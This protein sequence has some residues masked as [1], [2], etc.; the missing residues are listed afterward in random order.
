MN[1]LDLFDKL[2]YKTLNYSVLLKKVRFDSVVRYIIG[3]TANL[4]LPIYFSISSNNEGYKLNVNDDGRQQKLVVSLTSFPARIA[5]VH[6]VIEC[7]LRQTIKPSVII[8]WLSKQQFKSLN[9]L[10]KALLDLQ[11]RGL[12]IKIVN[13][14]IRSHKKYYYVMKT[15]PNDIII[16]VD[17]DIFYRS[18]MIQTLLECAKDNPSSIIANYA[19]RIRYENH[20][21]LP[22]NLWENNV[23]LK[24]A[25]GYDIFFGS[26]GGTLFRPRLLSP[27]VLKKEVFLK[28]CS[29]ADDIWLNAMCRINGTEVVKT[30]Y[31]SILLPVLSKSTRLTS[32]NVGEGLNDRQM[33][34]VR[35]YCV[36]KINIDPFKERLL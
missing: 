36:K 7:L 1:I 8:I 34:A 28:I 35:D 5:K 9:E 33:L 30:S 32:T 16:T 17:D 2:Y 10:P 13:E 29:H 15:Y 24:E 21:P 22:Y 23:N 14:D 12:T 20:T 19:H 3:K 4:L 31:N 26:G 25:S 11:D 18:D 6:L 27:L